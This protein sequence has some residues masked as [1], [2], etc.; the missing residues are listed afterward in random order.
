MN[1]PPRKPNRP[2]TRF[3]INEALISVG[4]P[5]HPEHDRWKRDREEDRQFY[6]REG[7]DR[8][9]PRT[10]KP[11]RELMFE[12]NWVPCV[13]MGAHIGPD[14]LYHSQHELWRQWEF[15]KAMDSPHDK[16]RRREV[17][18]VRK[19]T[20]YISCNDPV[21]QKARQEAF[22]KLSP[23]QQLQWKDALPAVFGHC[24]L[25]P[26]AQDL[27]EKREARVTLPASQRWWVRLL[28]WVKC[29]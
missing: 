22:S 20:G 17:E 5:R 2:Y 15:D 25:T 4:D 18:S 27:K 24:V 3:L 1:E 14:H 19:S 26:E 10:H 23:V 29:W 8:R 7:N 6:L 28:E 12:P 9:K 21:I 13:F 11:G 16:R